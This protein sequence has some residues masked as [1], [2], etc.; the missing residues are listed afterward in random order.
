MK[1]RKYL[2]LIIFMLPFF[3]SA[4]MKTLNDYQRMVDKYKS[5]YNNAQ[6]KLNLTDAEIKKIK[7]NIEY[8]KNKQIQLHKEVYENKNKI[9]QY[10]KEIKKKE[11][12]IKNILNF[13]SIS[14]NSNFYLDYIFEAENVTD[15]IYRT[16]VSEQLISSFHTQSLKLEEMVNNLIAREKQID[17][18]NKSL[19]VNQKK[20]EAETVK[21]GEERYIYEAAGVNAKTQMKIYDDQ[22]QMYKRLGCKPNDVIGRDCAT[23]QN[24]GKFLRPITEGRVTDE[25]RRR[26]YGIHPALDI[27]GNRNIYPLGYGVVTGKFVA[28]GANCLAITYYK[29]GRYY[30]SVYAHLASYEPGIRVGSKVTPYQKVATMGNTGYFSMGVHLHL[31]F[32]QCRYSFDDRCANYGRWRKFITNNNQKARMYI[33]FPPLGV[34]FRGR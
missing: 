4:E 5:D 33:N 6:R 22:L 26:S 30:S 9:E 18:L 7:G 16:T 11:T 21:L 1:K 23:Q 2:L 29:D 3:M 15:L 8:I 32:G 24:A 14:E 19:A 17:E 13:T 31:E 28:S 20:L 34:Y 12:D 25:F 10:R 27:A